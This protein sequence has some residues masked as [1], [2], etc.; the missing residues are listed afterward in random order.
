LDGGRLAGK[1]GILKPGGQG[2]GAKHLREKLGREG[3]AARE[4]D[5]LIPGTLHLGMQNLCHL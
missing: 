2:G 3:G 5:E 1:P 4:E